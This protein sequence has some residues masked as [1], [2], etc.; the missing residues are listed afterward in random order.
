MWLPLHI[1]LPFVL[2]FCCQISVDEAMDG[3]QLYATAS[4]W[5][6]LLDLKETKWQYSHTLSYI[7]LQEDVI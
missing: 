4:S 7:G 3:W 6:T 5:M 1:A 2:V